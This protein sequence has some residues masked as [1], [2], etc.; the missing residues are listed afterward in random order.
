MVMTYPIGIHPPSP[1]ITHTIEQSRLYK[2]ERHV[3]TDVDLTKSDRQDSQGTR[4]HFI[5]VLIGAILR[6]SAGLWT[7]L[8][9]LCTPSFQ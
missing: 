9:V 4:A 2:P 1:T 7:R 6:S 5:Q 8:L 3:P